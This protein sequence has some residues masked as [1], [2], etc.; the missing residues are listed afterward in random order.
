MNDSNSNKGKEPFYKNVVYNV[1]YKILNVLFP[2]VS[3]AIISRILLPSGVGRVSSAQNIVQYFTFIA[4]LGLSSYGTR[5]I[6]KSSYG[7]QNKL[8]FELFYINFISST[9]CLVF[10]YVMISRISFFSNYLL[11]YKVVGISIFLNYFNVDWFYQGKE[12]Y[13]YIAIRSTAVKAVML[14]AIILFV[15]SADDYIIYAGIV[16]FATAGNYFLNILNLRKYKVTFCYKG[17]EIKKHLAPLLILL[18]SNIAVELYSLVD[19]TMLTI[20][21]SSETVGYYTNAMRLT[22]VAI[23]VITAIGGVALP[24]IAPLVLE[25]KTNEVESVINNLLKAMFFL[26]IPAGLGMTVL[27]DMIVVVLFGESF[28]GAV[29]TV[30]ILTVLFYVFTFSNFLGTQVLV[31]YNREKNILIS[32]VFGSIVNILLN[33]FLIRLYAQNGAAIASVISEF[34]VTIITIYFVKQNLSINIPKKFL[35]DTISAGLLMCVFLYYLKHYMTLNIIS[36]VLLIDIALIVYFIF[37]LI[38]KNEIA[39]SF[40]VFFKTKIFKD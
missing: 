30:R 40:Y 17:L 20:M 9:I 22:K 10:Y 25:K 11:L 28:L 8:F 38:F 12:Q 6:A 15:R 31:A 21:C 13:R 37:I 14:V 33:S 18:A 39:I 1:L 34:I 23:F 4:P 19:T 26:A 2:L 27:A 29:P 3:T 5:E 36:L 32:T 7:T 16:C 35:T 24:K